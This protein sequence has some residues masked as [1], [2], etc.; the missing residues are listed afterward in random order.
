MMPCVMI[1]AQVRFND[2]VK[3]PFAE[4]THTLEGCFFDGPDAP[5]A[6]RMAMRAAQGQDDRLPTACLEQSVTGLCALRVPVVE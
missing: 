1:R 3:R 4:H 2:K 6:M 5:F